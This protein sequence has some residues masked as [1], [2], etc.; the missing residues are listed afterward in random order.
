MLYD[1]PGYISNRNEFLCLPKDLCKHVYGDLISS[2]PKVKTTQMSTDSRM[3]TCIAAYL[4]NDFIALV[5]C[6]S[7]EE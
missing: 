6:S 2:R 3:G 5:L 4:H 1:S 7:E